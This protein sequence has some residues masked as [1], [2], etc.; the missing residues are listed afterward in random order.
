MRAPRRGRPARLAAAAPLVQHQ[1]PEQAAA[2]GVVHR[3]ARA[4]AAV[5]ECHRAREERLFTVAAR[6]THAITGTGEEA[7][8][9]EQERAALCACRRVAALAPDA[10]HPRSELLGLAHVKLALFC[11]QKDR[12]AAARGISHVHTHA[13]GSLD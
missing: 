1:R 9:L 6:G 2:P 7:R 3:V 12:V 10:V 13:A 8:V 4:A 11:N 5:Q